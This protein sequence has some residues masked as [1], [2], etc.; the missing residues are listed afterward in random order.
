MSSKVRAKAGSKLHT[1]VR[2][3]DSLHLDPAN[4]RKH[5]GANLAAIKASLVRFGQQH[6]LVVDAKG[7]VVAGNGRLEAMRELGWTECQV[8]ETDLE[9]LDLAAFA[10]ADNRTAEL[11]GW[12]SA[13]LATT[14]RALAEDERGIE[15]TGFA[16]PDIEKFAALSEEVA[17]SSRSA[18]PEAEREIAEHPIRLLVM[19]SCVQELEAAL[20]KVGEKCRATGL[21]KICR[22]YL[23]GKADGNPSKK[24]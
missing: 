16:Q 21:A 6:P 22:H 8:V 18:P 5:D 10:I 19:P 11:A 4:A 20:L 9:G 23:E 24:G 13:A 14:L 7:M 3:L 1:S 12:D 15:G 17:A 2:A